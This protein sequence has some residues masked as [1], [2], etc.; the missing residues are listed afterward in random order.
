MK[1]DQFDFELPEACIA[2]HAV[3]PRDCAKLLVV[4]E[5][6]LQDRVVRELTEFL[7]AGDVL[8]L[9]DTRVIPARLYGKRGD[10]TVEIFLHK[11]LA[12]GTWEA[13]AKPAKRLQVLDCVVFGEDFS[14]QVVAKRED[15]FIELA[16][17]E[18]ESDLLDK[19]H[20]YGVTPLPPYIKRDKEKHAEDEAR[21]QTVYAREHGSVAA[22]TAG[23]HFTD[24]LL[25]RIRAMGVQIAFVTLHVG[26]GTFLPMKV[27]DTEAHVMHKERAVVSAHTA[28]LINSSKRAGGRVVAVG[29]T[30]M[31][32]LE[33]AADEEGI[34]HPYDS[35]TGIF[36]TPGYRFRLCDLL[37]TNF[38]LPK[39]TLF[40]LV[41]AFSG[42]ERMKN[43]Y[44]YAIEKSYRFYSY[45]DACLL[46]RLP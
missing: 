9:N 5:S 36:I 43:A 29:T 17:D 23:L 39:S 44:R 16:F 11:P 19:L 30:S 38:H 25:A 28:D 12:A 37:M 26:A 31:R 4:G 45:G 21:Y 14:V 13:L 3:E 27:D 46:Y 41:S 24:D 32:T 20:R 42:L 15:G 40:M 18:T 1:V 34:L 35:E 6:G 2:Q 22:P 10:A 8:V 33:S 7:K